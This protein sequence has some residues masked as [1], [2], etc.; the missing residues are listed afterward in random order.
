MTKDLNITTLNEGHMHE[1]CDRASM[2]SAMFDDF[3][4]QHPAV[5]GTPELKEKAE[6]IS[7]ALGDFY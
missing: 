6:I 1:A 7:S 5:M 2:L 3:L 4:T